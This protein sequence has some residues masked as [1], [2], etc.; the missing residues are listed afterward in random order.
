MP[1]TRGG[2][3]LRRR[4]K[5]KKIAR[6]DIEIKMKSIQQFAT[7]WIIYVYKSIKVFY[8]NLFAVHSGRRA[9]HRLVEPETIERK[10]K[11]KKINKNPPK[12]KQHKQNTYEYTDWYSI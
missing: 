9:G 8:P 2:N 3:K 12:F 11:I 6:R 7:T 5:I 10:K 1:H 4:W